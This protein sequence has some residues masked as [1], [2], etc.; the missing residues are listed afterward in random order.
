VNFA[1]GASFTRA[2]LWTL[3]PARSFS[4]RLSVTF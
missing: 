3:P 1:G 2:Q 4:G